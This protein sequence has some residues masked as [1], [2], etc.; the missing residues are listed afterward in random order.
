MRPSLVVI[1][2]TLLFLAFLLAPLNATAQS[3]PAQ[4]PPPPQ[5]TPSRED[6]WD[7][8]LERHTRWATIDGVRL[9]AVDY[10]AVRV[11]PDWAVLMRQLRDAPEPAGRDDRVAFWLNA[12]NIL[13]ID[14]VTR[15]YPVESIRDIGGTLFNRVWSHDVAEVAGKV[16]S[17]GEVEHE[18]LR[19]VGGARV[20]AA[21]VCASVSCPPLR[22]EA[23]RGGRLKEQLDDQI[24][25]WLNNPK[26][27]VQVSADGK[28]VTVSQIFDFFKGDFEKESGTVWGFIKPRI[29]AKL[30]ARVKVDS[31]RIRYLDYNW[32][33][34]DAARARK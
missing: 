28:T 25:L 31:P 6:H 9:V 2:F 4:A 21:I 26:I 34:N 1:S 27:G 29:D 30:A 3:M 14:L 11:D 12:Y 10:S 22:R 32:S 15:N 13:A 16:R 8:L 18:I 5:A 19:E 23:Y 33:L 24:D 17:L 20:H 7:A